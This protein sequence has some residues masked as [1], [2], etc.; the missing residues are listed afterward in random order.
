MK[1]SMGY[2]PKHLVATLMLLVVAAALTL[3]GAPRIAAADTAVQT[4]HRLYNPYTGEHFYT[5][6]TNERDQLSGIGWTYEG[7]GWTAPGK[8]NTP[9]Y[10]LYN[11]YA[12]GGDHHY[13]MSAQERDELKKAGWTDEGVGWYSDDA[14]GVPLYRQYNP[15]AST[16]T[17]NYTADKNENDVLVSKGWRE[18]GVAWYGV[19][20]EGFSY[21]AYYIDGRGST[22]YSGS[23]RILY[24]KTDNPNGTF[25]LDAGDSTVSM[26]AL[27]GDD[28]V[29]VDDQ[30]QVR[31]YLKVP[32]GYVAEFDLEDGS[33][34]SK[35]L[36]LIEERGLYGGVPVCNLTVNYVNSDDAI[37]QW[38]DQ[39]IAQYSNSSMNSL[40]KMEAISSGL[41]RDFKYMPMYEDASGYLEFAAKPNSPFFVSGVWESYTSPAVLCK[42]A[43]RVGGF[44]DIHNCY[45][46]YPVGST[47]WS[48]TH[49]FMTAKYNGETHR[50]EACPMPDTNYVERGSV[51]PIDFTN[52]SQFQKA[53]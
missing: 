29:D 34:G 42:I 7:I 51:K 4:M 3:C 9:V 46:D 49:W 38:I 20:T 5:A 15:Y 33:F 10:R 19:K 17:H 23:P 44:T 40:Q 8:S 39:K 50:F 35:K 28:F 27:Q 21:E 52:V 6:D 36:S 26:Y 48:N 53:S 37:N 11:S 13:T 47:E 1:M 31:N 30:G 45:F 43:E 12:P 22:W 18:E 16:G 24:I 25:H 14:K 32:G 2:M 41:R